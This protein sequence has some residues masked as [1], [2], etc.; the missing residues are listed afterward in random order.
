M[1]VIVTHTIAET[2]ATIYNST[3]YA[4]QARS[5]HAALMYVNA[6]RT[7]GDSPL[8]VITPNPLNVN[9]WVFDPM[10]D[11]HYKAELLMIPTWT[12]AVSGSTGAEYSQAPINT[13]TLV[14]YNGVFYRAVNEIPFNGTYPT[15]DIDYNNWE[16]LDTTNI[17]D[18]YDEVLMQSPAF[19]PYA[20]TFYGFEEFVFYNNLVYSFLNLS[21]EI[22]KSC[23]ICA[24]PQ[25]EE[26]RCLRDKY[27]SVELA[28]AASNYSGAQTIIESSE[29]LVNSCSC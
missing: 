25:I 14:Y 2:S 1:D 20:K 6:K 24:N 23:N 29:N 17:V 13:G 7:T 28:V 16:V 5:D 21:A 3:A 27:E 18:V 15:P 8:I 19:P 4:G 9:E 26:L 22:T 12:T 11:N 10:A